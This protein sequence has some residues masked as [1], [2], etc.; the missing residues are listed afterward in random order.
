MNAAKNDRKRRLGGHF[1]AAVGA[2]TKRQK[3]NSWRQE[4][5]EEEEATGAP[6]AAAGTSNK[7]DAGPAPLAVLTGVDD[8]SDAEDMVD[9]GT[10]LPSE[11]DDEV[12]AER[13]VASE[14]QEADVVVD[15][16]SLQ[17]QTAGEGAAGATTVSAVA[18]PCGADESHLFFEA[19]P[20]VEV[21]LELVIGETASGSLRILL[22]DGIDESMEKRLAAC[23]PPD[24]AAVEALARGKFCTFGGH[25]AVPALPSATSSRASHALHACAGLLS[26]PRNQPAGLLLTLGPQPQLD[27]SHIVLGKV[28]AGGLVVRRLDALAPCCSATELKPRVSPLLL[29]RVIPSL[30]S[31]QKSDDALAAAELTTPQ[32]EVIVSAPS[33]SGAADASGEGQE[34]TNG[35]ASDL[36]VPPAAGAPTGFSSQPLVQ[37]EE[38]DAAAMAAEVLEVAELEINGRDAEVTELKQMTFSRERVEGVAAVEEHLGMLDQKLTALDCSDQALMFQRS[39]LQERMRHLIRLLNKLK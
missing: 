14:A 15:A 37:E 11:P 26:A 27:A 23:E 8:A 17:G 39:W 34:L 9:P 30:P 2:S 28:L 25:A 33:S 18:A 19:R 24:G 5:E 20:A 12:F 10:P 22:P 3:D 4:L 6:G 36:P 32:P 29:R 16:T 35:R 1:G 31:V 38:L 7:G 13:G 21:L